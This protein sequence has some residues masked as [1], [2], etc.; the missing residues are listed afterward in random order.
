MNAASSDRRKAIWP[1]ISSAEEG[2]AAPDRRFDPARRDRVDADAVGRGFLGRDPCQM[3]DRRLR[4][5]VGRDAGF[6]L[7]P[8]DRGGEHD[9]AAAAGGAD[10]L[11][12]GLQRQKGAVEIDAHHPPPLLEGQLRDRAA[13]ADAGI[14]DGV[15]Q[16]GEV[17]SGP[18][19]LVGDVAD[20]RLALAG[21]G[22]AEIPEL[23]LVAVDQDE[24]AR[25]G[26]GEA[27]RDGRA[28]AGGGTGDEHA[29]V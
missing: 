24:L 12:R 17:G 4:G 27:R 7:D 19:C 15:G 25:A 21:K 13:L 22:E 23:H 28:D 18:Q 1:A 14:D 8:G 10:R 5:R 11:Q 20:D 29:R 26:R 3:D 9:R 2:D 6:G 16:P